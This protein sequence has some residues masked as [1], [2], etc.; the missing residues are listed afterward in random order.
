M[1]AAATVLAACFHSYLLV[2]HLVLDRSRSR[3]DVLCCAVLCASCS[4]SLSLFLAVA[5]TA[6][7]STEEEEGREEELEMNK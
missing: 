3:H 7:W 4:L 6:R 2:E 1:L 5:P